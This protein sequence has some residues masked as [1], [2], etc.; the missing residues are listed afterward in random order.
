VKVDELINVAVTSLSGTPVS[1]G[2]GSAVLIY[3]V[4]NTGNGS[5]PFKLTADPAVSGNAFN[6]ATQSLAID[7]NGNGTYD[8]GVDAL[9]TNGANGPAMAP[10]SSLKVFVLS[11][12][13]STA[14]DGQTSQVRL[15]AA[16]IVGTGTAGTVFAGKGASGVDAVIGA[17][18]GTANALASVIASLANLSLTK[19]AVVA[20][21]FGGTTSVPGSLVT[22]SLL[23]K[24]SGTGT[25]TGVH[26]TD[27]FPAGT[28]YQAGTLTLNGSAQTDVADTDS[29][30]ASSTGIDV[31]LGNLT[32]ASGDKTVTFKVKIN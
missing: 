31:A 15:S 29:G 1:G 17:S 20:D 25:A 2:S 12:V 5:Q 28:T 3:Q 22:Y 6:T 8:A 19:S 30:T 24:T 18:T 4:T 13:P 16:S 11:N 32:S 9:L 27:A 23:L 26:I 10:D 14:T 7:T 21:P